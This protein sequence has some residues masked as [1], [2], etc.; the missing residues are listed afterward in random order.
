MWHI[1]AAYSDRGKE[2]TMYRKLYS[3]LT[4]LENGIEILEKGLYLCLLVTLVFTIFFQV[5]GRYFIGLATPWAEELARY[6]FVWI[7]WIVG[8][9][10]LKRG[11]HIVM[12]LIDSSLEK[13]KNPKFAFYL[14]SKCSYSIVIIFMCFVIKYFMQYFAKVYSSG[15]TTPAN[16]I[17]TWIILCGVL[18]GMILSIV[19]SIYMLLAP[20]DAEEKEAG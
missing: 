7:S 14:V 19:Q 13:T 2:R 15:R 1:C 10:S 9:L 4:K 17:P 11:G 8:A 18:L 20:Y 3:A 5:M 6:S 16:N 12:N